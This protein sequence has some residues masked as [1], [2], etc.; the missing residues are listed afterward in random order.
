[1]NFSNEKDILDELLSFSVPIIPDST[2]FWMVRTQKGY[3]YTEFISK[4]FVAIAWNIIDSKSDFSDSSKE[5]L[6]DLIT[7]EYSD[8]HRPSTVIN[9]CHNFIHEINPC[10]ILIIPSKGSKYVTFA[11]AGCYYEENSKTVEL[12]HTV[13]DR[14]QNNEIAINEVSCPYK[15]RR[16]IELLRTI[17]GEDLNYA[18]YRAISNY[19]GLSNLDSYSRQILNTLY[20]CYSFQG[21][22][23]IVY[24]VRKT[25]PI[26]PSE[27][28]GL[29]YSNTTCLSKIISE[30]HI[31]TQIS[32]N[33]PGDFVFIIENIWE[34]AKENWIYIFGLLIFIGGGKAFS[35]QIDG[36]IDIVKKILSAPSDVKLKQYEVASK[37]MDLIEKR[38]EIYEKI[39]AAGV[40]PSD[41]EEPLNVLFEKASSLKTEPIVLSTDSSIPKQDLEELQIVDLDDDQE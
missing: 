2:R 17:K 27:L 30:D 11:K 9:K 10:D 13:I 20:N 4:K 33:S 3:F 1:M 36:I 23:A 40:N 18:L 26:K 29:L 8:I 24:N 19:H 6:Q 16:K 38:L 28:S 37:E 25:T 15:K 22:A 31:S 12:E 39:K 14:I 41:L 7:M 21:S 34:F 35:F 5:S 32:L